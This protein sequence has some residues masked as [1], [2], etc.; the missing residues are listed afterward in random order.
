MVRKSKVVKKQ[1]YSDSDETGSDNDQ[2]GQVETKE[3]TPKKMKKVKAPKKAPK[4]KVPKKAL[5]EDKPK[6]PKTPWM[7]HMS[8]FRT[9]NPNMAYKESLKAASI[10]YKAMKANA[11][12]IKEPSADVI[13]SDDEEDDQM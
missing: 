6:K 4:K 3:E 5:K 8:E 2:H 9:E 12:A 10:T 1:E 7:I 13:D 11:I